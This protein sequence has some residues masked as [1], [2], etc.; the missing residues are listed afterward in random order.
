[1]LKK[2]LFA[3]AALLTSMGLAFAGVEANTAD[4]AASDGIKGLG[5]KTSKAIIAERQQGGSF[6]DWTDFSSRVKGIGDKSA[7]RLSQSGLT[8]NGRA[9]PG[10]PLAV[11]K[12]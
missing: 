2:C 7:N 12:P 3:L 11:T 1:M 4:Q 8:V 5:P 6:K 10:A 9:K